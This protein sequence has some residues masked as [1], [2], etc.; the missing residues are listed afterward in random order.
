MN[1]ELEND[2][3]ERINIHL[4]TQS[5]SGFS[6]EIV[7]LAGTRLADFVRER[8]ITTDFLVRVNRE[9]HS[10]DYILQDGDRVSATAHS[11]KGAC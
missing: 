7:I 11:V 2:G 8:N 9:A 6:E 4:I 1:S 3:R 10:A 5:G